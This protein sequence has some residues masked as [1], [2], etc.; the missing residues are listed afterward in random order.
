[1][2]ISAIKALQ[3]WQNLEK[4]WLPTY[5]WTADPFTLWQERI[6]FIICF[7]ATVFGPF[8]LIPF[9]ILSVSTGFAN[10]AILDTIAY[11]A[12]VIILFSRNTPFNIRATSVFCILYLLGAGLLFF[13]G[14]IGSGYIWLLGA[15]IIIGSI[16]DFRKL[17]SQFFIDAALAGN[18]QYFEWAHQLKNGAIVESE[19]VLNRL[20]LNEK[21]YLQAVVRNITERKQ[22]ED[23]LRESEARLYAVFN[24]VE[25]I[26]VQG[27]DRERRMIFWNRASQ[28]VYGYTSDEAH[29]QKLENLIIPD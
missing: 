27:Y 23:K 21:F 22:A 14:P 5:V 9:I 19:I 16:Y 20:I 10:V 28:D 1:M 12:A 2:F 29:G 26:P 11:V 24:A 13:L 8:A 7:T 18:P 17:K 25:S 3:F 15:S 6:L 4:K